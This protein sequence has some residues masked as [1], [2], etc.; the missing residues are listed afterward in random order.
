MK[1]D[2]NNEDFNFVNKSY[3]FS[4]AKMQNN[5]GKLINQNGTPTRVSKNRYGNSMNSVFVKNNKVSMF[6]DKS[7]V[8]SRK[9]LLSNLKVNR[10]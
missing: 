7:S 10:F 9:K 5:F 4:T 6:M 2:D 3:D 1:L 8:I